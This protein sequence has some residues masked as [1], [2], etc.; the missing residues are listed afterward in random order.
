MLGSQANPQ[1][2]FSHGTPKIGVPD[3][4]HPGQPFHVRDIWNTHIQMRGG[5]EEASDGLRSQREPPPQ[6]KS[7]INGGNHQ[8]LGWP[9]CLT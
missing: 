8:Y 2:F 6:N 4:S 5:N 9:Y 1:F 3:W 7:E